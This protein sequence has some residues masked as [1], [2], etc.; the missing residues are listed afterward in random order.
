MRICDLNSGVG[1]LTQA[2][3]DLKDRWSE[4]KSHWN[5]DVRKQFEATHLAEIPTRLTQLLGAAQRLAEVL[6]KAAKDCGDEEAGEA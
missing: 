6:D 2:F 1:Q 4:A 3:S 5:D